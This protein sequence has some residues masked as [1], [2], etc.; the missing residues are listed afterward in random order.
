MKQIITYLQNQKEIA[1]VA[2]SSVLEKGGNLFDAKF[3]L[4][5]IVHL[6]TMLK[7]LEDAK[8]KRSQTKSK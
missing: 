6:E 8:E 1:Y 2:Y 7:D 3:W 5:R 4:E